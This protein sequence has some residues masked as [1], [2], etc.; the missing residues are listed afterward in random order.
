MFYTPFRQSR[1]S[2]GRAS[3]WV[4]APADGGDAEKGFAIKLVSTSFLL[5]LVRHLLLEGMHLLLLASC[6][7][8][9][10]V[11]R[12]PHEISSHLD[13]TRSHKF[14]DPRMLPGPPHWQSDRDLA[15]NLIDHL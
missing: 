10:S 6:F 1:W 11:A 4:S 7:A 13:S 2:H 14:D 15:E 5:L 8:S 12:S 3:P 9:E